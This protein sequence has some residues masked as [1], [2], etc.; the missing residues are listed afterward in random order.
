MHAREWS[1]DRTVAGRG[2]H[3][4]LVY[5][6][7]TTLP[8][9]LL[10]VHELAVMIKQNSTVRCSYLLAFRIYYSTLWGPLCCTRGQ[11]PGLVPKVPGGPA[12]AGPCVEMSKA[13]FFN[14]WYTIIL[15]LSL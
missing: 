5:H 12:I 2:S 6:N 11:L 7:F 10:E 13:M 8:V 3:P 1:C 14:Q 15:P 4:G 9:V